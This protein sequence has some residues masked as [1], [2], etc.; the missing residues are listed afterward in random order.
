MFK[1]MAAGMIVGLCFVPFFLLFFI[2]M[3]VFGTLP[4]GWFSGLHHP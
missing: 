3:A 4:G 1:W 2:V